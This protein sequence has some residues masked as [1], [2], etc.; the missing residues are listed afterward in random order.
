MQATNVSS[1]TPGNYILEVSD[2]TK[3]LTKQISVIR[4]CCL[5]QIEFNFL[6]ISVAH[7]VFYPGYK[8]RY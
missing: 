5:S 7:I 6:K 4:G 8:S 3:T 1:L 2:G